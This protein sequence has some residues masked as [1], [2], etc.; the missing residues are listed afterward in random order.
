VF[1]GCQSD[2]LKRI[3]GAKVMWLSRAPCGK[4]IGADDSMNP[5]CNVRPGGVIDA[6][7]EINLETKDGATAFGE[8][9]TLCVL[10]TPRCE[11]QTVLGVGIKVDL[12]SGLHGTLG[13]TCQLLGDKKTVFFCEFIGRS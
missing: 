10:E 12:T 8:R 13:N 5:K 1:E 4:A 3:V 6:R 11:G 2:R 7:L 9:I